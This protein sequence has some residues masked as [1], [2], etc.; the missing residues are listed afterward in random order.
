[1]IDP[2]LIAEAKELCLAVAPELPAAG[3][4]LYLLEHPASLPKPSDTAAY[5]CGGTCIAI[6]DELIARGE[7]FGP[8]P[9]ICLVDPCQS[10]DE[11]NDLLGVALHELA[12]ELPARKYADSEP[13]AM[14]RAMQAKVFTELANEDHSGLRTIP[15]AGHESAWIRRVLH[16]HHR[17][18]WHGRPLP[19]CSLRAAGASYGLS[20]ITAYLK[21]LAPELTEML[22]FSFR[23]IEL[24]DPPQEFAQLWQRDLETLEGISR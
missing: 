22:S 13:T 4:P 23:E 24:F 10:G 8:G 20:P 6:R 15:L 9:M 7:W 12:H 14:H 21:A 5:S 18:L 17:A 1:M 3:I 2:A 11:R 16:L 19:L